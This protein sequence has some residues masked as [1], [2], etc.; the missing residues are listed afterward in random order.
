MPL[1]VIRRDSRYSSRPPLLSSWGACWVEL[2]GPWTPVARWSSAAAASRWCVARSSSPAFVATSAA[3]R[4][5]AAAEALASWARRPASSARRAACAARSRASAARSLAAAACSSRSGTAPTYVG[6][7]GR[8]TSHWTPHPA[9]IMMSARS[10]R[11]VFPRRG[12]WPPRVPPGPRGRPPHQLRVTNVRGRTHPAGGVTWTSLAR[13]PGHD[14]RSAPEMRTPQ[15]RIGLST[16]WASS[17]TMRRARTASSRLD[18]HQQ[19][20]IGAHARARRDSR[21]SSGLEAGEGAAQPLITRHFE[22]HAWDAS[23]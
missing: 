5:A 21:R 8:D 13:R 10:P 15:S 7:I 19:Q 1:S 22:P 18:R 16:S 12:R 6:D 20:R 17:S 11:W 2:C 4:C 3:P 14:P 23:H 9:W